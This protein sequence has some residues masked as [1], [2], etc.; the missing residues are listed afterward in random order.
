MLLSVTWSVCIGLHNS[1]DGY[2]N[3][4]SAIFVTHLGSARLARLHPFRHMKPSQL[5]CQT[6][7]FNPH[8]A[9]FNESFALG[10]V[11][12]LFLVLMQV[13]RGVEW[14]V[15]QDGWKQLLFDICFTYRPI[16]HGLFFLHI[17]CLILQQIQI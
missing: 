16:M 13:V 3:D 17:T 8:P 7:D 2:D 9:S 6:L 1:I 14:R 15:N 11:T 12:I 10:C 5:V 4:S